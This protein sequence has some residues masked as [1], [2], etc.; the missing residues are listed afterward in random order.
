MSETSWG[1]PGSSETGRGTLGE[2]RDG[3]GDPQ[4]GPRHVGGASRW[5]VTGQET[6]GEFREGSVDH[7]GDPGRVL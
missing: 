1:T 6:L 4:G 5:S 7:R 2:V 3:L